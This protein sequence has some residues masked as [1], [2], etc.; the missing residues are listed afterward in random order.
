M[1]FSELKRQVILEKMQ[2]KKNGK[3]LVGKK[4]Q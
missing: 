2:Y 1:T 3:L 4:N